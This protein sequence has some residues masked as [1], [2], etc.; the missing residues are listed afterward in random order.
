MIV[1][2]LLRGFLDLIQSIIFGAETLSDLSSSFG[3]DLVS[4]AVQLTV[5]IRNK[6]V[7][8]A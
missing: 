1:T 6:T 5:F 8:I 7:A 2:R 4:S 3:I